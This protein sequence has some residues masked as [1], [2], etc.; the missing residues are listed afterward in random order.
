MSEIQHVIMRDL[1]DDVTISAKDVVVEIQKGLL[2]KRKALRLHGSVHSEAEKRKVLQIVA[3][4]AGDSFD[5]KDE[6]E[7]KS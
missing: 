5:V 7:I 4:H 3:H 2:K 6:L 1:E